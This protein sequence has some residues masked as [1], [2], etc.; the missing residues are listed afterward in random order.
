MR[1]LT[2][3]AMTMALLV[4]T[5]LQ[6]E[7][8]GHRVL[9]YGDSNT[10]GW[11][12]CSDGFPTIRLSPSQRWAGLLGQYLGTGYEVEEDGLNLRT[13]DLDD[14]V[15]WGGQLVARDYNGAASLPTALA[16]HAPLDLVVL[17]LGQNDLQNREPPRVS[18]RLQTVRGRS[19]EEDIEEIRA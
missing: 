17:A 7:D 15:G 9:V 11:K 5:P 3:L 1:T 12:A 14:P 2:K 16:R 6:A 8:D 4:A 13:T 18:R 10:W 19:H